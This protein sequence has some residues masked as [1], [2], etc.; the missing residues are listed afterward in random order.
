MKIKE[1]PV[2]QFD[3][4][5]EHAKEKARDWYR[6]GAL[7][8]MIGEIF[9]EDAETIGLIITGFRLD[10]DR[11]ATGKLTKSV[12]EVCQ[13]IHTNHGNACDTY[14][15]ATEYLGKI[16]HVEQAE[17]NDEE[18]HEDEREEIEEH[19]KQG[20]LEEYSILLQ[21]EYEYLL[22]DESV[23]ESITTNEYE[24]TEDGTRF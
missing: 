7:D 4:L 8:S 10:R 24:F 15:L 16:T 20:L 22:S 2:Y 12:K 13:L 1:T 19:F 9:T 5:S 21:H 11:H 6:T 3:E 17:S 18:D 14:Q 23:D